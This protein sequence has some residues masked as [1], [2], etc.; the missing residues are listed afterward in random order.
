MSW[1]LRFP[2]TFLPWI[3]VSATLVT[4]ARGADD[5]GH[6]L[7]RDGL[8]GWVEE[9][10]EEAGPAADTG[11]V[12]TFAEGIL[13]CSGKGFGFLRHDRVYDDFTAEIEYRFPKRGNSGIGVRTVPYDGTRPTRPS[14]AAYEIQL[15]SDKGAKP[16]PGASGSLYGHVAPSEITAKPVGEWNV[17]V[18][19]CRGPL[20]RIIHNG[21]EVV[22]Y[23]QSTRPTT[24]TKPLAGFLCLQNH[25]SLIEFRSVRVRPLAS[26]GQ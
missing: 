10:G 26:P 17:I 9:Q 15:L 22:N 25:G 16:Y 13:R 7:L 5:A 2:E 11:P 1:L 3:V 24:A 12:W 21:V 8:T 20:I 6:D 4:A 23:D 18:V 14:S 19:E